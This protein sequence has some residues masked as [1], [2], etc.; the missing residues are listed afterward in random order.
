MFLNACFTSDHQTSV[1]SIQVRHVV[2]ALIMTSTPLLCSELPRSYPTTFIYDLVIQIRAYTGI[3]PRYF[4]LW[5]VYSSALTVC[6]NIIFLCQFKTISNFFQEISLAQ[7]QPKCKKHNDVDKISSC[8]LSSNTWSINCPGQQRSNFINSFTSNSCQKVRSFLK[9]SGSPIPR[10]PE[11]GNRVILGFRT[12]KSM[13]I[14]A[15]RILSV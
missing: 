7:F 10:F 5:A 12:Y 9:Y 6:K 15:V 3:E 14:E 4:Q 8:L 2:G 13:S 1:Q 11:S